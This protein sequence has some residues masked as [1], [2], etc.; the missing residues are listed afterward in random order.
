LANKASF[1]AFLEK[2]KERA[3]RSGREFKIDLN[4]IEAMN[5]SE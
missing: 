2:Q 1:I 4:K 3:E 5:D